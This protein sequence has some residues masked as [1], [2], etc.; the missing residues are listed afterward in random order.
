MQSLKRT[1]ARFMEERLPS[2]MK[3]YFRYWEQVNIS[4]NLDDEQCG[5][6]LLRL[7]RQIPY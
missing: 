7:A 3:E 1:Y 5:R 6:L 4:E 2:E